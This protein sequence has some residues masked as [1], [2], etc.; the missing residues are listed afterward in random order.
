MPTGVILLVRKMPNFLEL[1]EATQGS[2]SKAINA[3]FLTY[4]Q[5][6]HSS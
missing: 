4:F 3:D 5:L 6:T 1:Q 2:F